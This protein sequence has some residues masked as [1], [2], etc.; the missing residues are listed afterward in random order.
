MLLIDFVKSICSILLFFLFCLLLFFKHVLDILSLSLQF[1]QIKQFCYLR[2]ASSVLLKVRRETI[3]IDNRS[4]IKHRFYVYS[5][6]KSK[7]DLILIWTKSAID[8]DQVS[9]SSNYLNSKI[10]EQ[11]KY[12]NLIIFG[13]SITTEIVISNMII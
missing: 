9:N 6:D 10:I 1:Y 3:K 8:L 4:S 12:I 13:S 7:H 11:L 2:S 5:E